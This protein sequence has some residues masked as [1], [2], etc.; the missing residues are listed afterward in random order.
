VDGSEGVRKRLFGVLVLASAAAL[1]SEGVPAQTTSLTFERPPAQGPGTPGGGVISDPTIQPFNGPGMPAWVA[2]GASIDL[3][4][5]GR[6]DVVVC[7]GSFPPAPAVKQP[8]RVLRP[9][10]DGSVVDVTRQLFG[11][12]ALPSSIHPREIVSG[13]FNRDGRA[14]IFVAAH[15]YDTAP[16]PGETNL[17]LISNADGTYTDRSA[18]LP[19]V[20]DFS[21]SACVG[22]INGDGRLD[23]YV[24]NVFGQL[25]VGPY[26]LIGK[27]DGTFTQKTSG[28]PPQIPSLQEGFLSCLLLD[29]DRDGSDD[30]VLGTHNAGGF[31]DSVVLFNDGTG[32]FTRRPRAVLPS[33][34]LPADNFL[35]LDIASLDVNLDGRPDL[36]LLSS[37]MQSNNGVGLQL[38]INLGNGTLVDETAR[39]APSIARLTGPVYPFIRLADFNGD[40][41]QD[42]YLEQIGGADD[43]LPRP[44]IWLNNG[45]GSLTPMAPS[46]LPQDFNSYA[47]LFAVDFDGDGRPDIVHLGGPPLGPSPTGQFIPYRSFLNRTAPAGPTGGAPGQPTVTTATATGSTLQITWTSGAGAPPTAHRLDFFAGSAA[48]ASLNVAAATTVSIPIPAGTAGSFAVRVTALSGAT[49]GPPSSPFPF[50]IG[51]SPG[52]GGCT[53]APA[54]PVVTGSIVAGTATVSWPAVQGAT[55]Y[56]VSAGS[57]QG[58]ANLYSPT[59]VGPNTTVSASGLPAGFSAWVRV[60]AVNACGQSPPG[61]FFLSAGSTP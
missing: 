42:F 2:M 49:A 37:A 39:L 31:V 34:P 53:A 56:I 17:L 51:S 58:A 33:G 23:I 30:L 36:L 41:L 8:C 24:G 50:T 59:N 26:L 5:N 19:Q 14:D 38:L 29:V 20:P 46:S 10:P 16:F 3:Q 47:S 25:R 1:I 22:D 57:T 45:N 18:T 12:G 6:P 28:L 21:H 48:V 54:S 44:R 35:V 13:D 61:D 7:H 60:I 40:G 15:G 4:G 52:G 43:G 27:G 32:D 55:S 11:A 9:Q